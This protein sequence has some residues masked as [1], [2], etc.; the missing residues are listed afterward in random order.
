[1]HL[2]DGVISLLS[3]NKV[4]LKIADSQLFNVERVEL[5][6]GAEIDKKEG[7]GTINV[8]FASG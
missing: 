6:N 8:D 2:G 4:F 1:M 5:S 7:L 3:L